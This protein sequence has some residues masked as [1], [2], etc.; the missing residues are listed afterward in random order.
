M[1]PKTDQLADFISRVS[2]E[3]LWSIDSSFLT[4]SSDGK[5]YYTELVN[6]PRIDNVFISARLLVNRE[7]VWARTLSDSNF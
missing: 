1:T 4:V 7:L 2:Y 5:V 3:V 6:V